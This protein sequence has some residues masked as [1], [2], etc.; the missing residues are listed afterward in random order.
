MVSLIF[1]F[2]Q[3]LALLGWLA[4]AGMGIGVVYGLY[5][6]YKHPMTKT[7]SVIYAAV[8]RFVWAVALAWV[9]Y[10]SKYGYGGKSSADVEQVFLV[11]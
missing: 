9:V 10:A 8:S 6:S 4:A 5:P 2:I 1:P 7:A 11:I 3:V